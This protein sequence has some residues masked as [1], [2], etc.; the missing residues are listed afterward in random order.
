MHVP[1]QDGDLSPLVEPYQ[2]A[3]HGPLHDA[4]DSP[5]VRPYRPALQFVQL[6]SPPVLYWPAA[7]EPLQFDVVRPLSDPYRPGSHGPLHDA[8]DSPVVLPYCP[9]LQFV[10]LTPPTL[11]VPARHE[12]QSKTFPLALLNRP[13]EHALP[14]EFIAPAPQ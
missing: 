9:A 14:Y 10:Q 4:V 7:Q 5:V 11:Y 6:D 13:G 3:A 2:P 1:E 12:V 8:V